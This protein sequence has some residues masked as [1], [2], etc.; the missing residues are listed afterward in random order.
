MVESTL[1]LDN[2]LAVQEISCFYET[3][4]D[5]LPCSRKPATGFFLIQMNSVPSFTSYLLWILL[6]SSHLHSDLP[7]GL[8]PS[9]FLTE[10]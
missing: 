7:S 6:F 4:K 9:R 10:I 3:Q 8:F 2:Y 5:L 1:R